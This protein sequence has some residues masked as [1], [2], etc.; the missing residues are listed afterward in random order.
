M[1]EVNNEPRSTMFLR[2]R[3]SVTVQHGNAARIL[4]TSRP[5]VG[6]SY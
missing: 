1:A 2:Q 5:V 4:G 3:L 6:G